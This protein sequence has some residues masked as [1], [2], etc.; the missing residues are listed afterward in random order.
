MFRF[1]VEMWR[2]ETD[3]HNRIHLV[4]RNRA[5][6]QIVSSAIPVAVFVE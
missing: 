1:G 2:L 3:L 6:L 5:L 4:Y